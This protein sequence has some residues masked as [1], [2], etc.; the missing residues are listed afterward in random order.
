VSFN[1]S[2]LNAIAINYTGYLNEPTYIWNQRIDNTQGYIAF[3]V[4]SHLPANPKTGGSPPPLITINFKGSG[5][6]TSPLLLVKTILVDGQAMEISHAVINATAQVELVPGHDVAVTDIISP[7]TVVCQGCSASFKVLVQNQGIFTE[8]FDI[9][10]SA[11]TLIIFTQQV[12]LSS[13]TSK[14]L[15]FV[16]VNISVALG[17]IIL[18]AEVTMS[19]DIDP[20]DNTLILKDTITVSIKGDINADGLV[21]IVDVAMAARA[22]GSKPGEERWNPNS[23]LNEDQQINIVDI[24]TI[25]RQFGKT[26]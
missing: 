21:N 23:D 24:A 15:T 6:G 8:V 13:G 14:V 7:K 22:F 3:A 12:T 17:D 2:V 9:I 10:L 18:K 26:R 5:V 11:N 16:W 4:S 19:G 20:T 25:A 1:S